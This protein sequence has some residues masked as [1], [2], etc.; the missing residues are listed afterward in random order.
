MLAVDRLRSQAPEPW[1]IEPYPDGGSLG[2]AQYNQ[3]VAA[4]SIARFKD[5]P[6]ARASCAGLVF[7]AGSAG[8]ERR[9]KHALLSDNR[10]DQV[11]RGHVEHWVPGLHALGG[12]P[13]AAR[14]QQL[15]RF[16]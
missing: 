13:L 8:K 5:G 11:T 3:R 15:S 16:A 7:D 14:L 1:T 10:I 2:P 6:S 12:N 9:P 4:G